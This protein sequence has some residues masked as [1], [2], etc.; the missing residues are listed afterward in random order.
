VKIGKEQKEDRK[1]AQKDPVKT[2]GSKA[3]GRQYSIRKVALRPG[4]PETP[5]FAKKRKPPPLARKKRGGK[6]L[7]F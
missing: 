6:R 5:Q 3:G 2:S 1:P 4:G 7:P